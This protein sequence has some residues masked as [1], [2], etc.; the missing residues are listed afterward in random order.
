VLQA[1]PSRLRDLRGTRMAMI[2]QEPMTAL[3]PVMTVGEPDRRGAGDP[4]QLSEPERRQR[5]LQVMRSVQC[6]S[7]SA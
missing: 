1:T 6:P 7:P 5:V 4:H 3:N 2:F